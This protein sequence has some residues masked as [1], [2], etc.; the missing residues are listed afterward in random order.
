MNM[1]GGFE[2]KT[3]DTQTQNI[4][5]ADRP[6]QRESVGGRKDADHRAQLKPWLS[7]SN[8]DM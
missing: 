8:R 6:Q 7:A 2:K 1:K 5:R 4:M 3:A